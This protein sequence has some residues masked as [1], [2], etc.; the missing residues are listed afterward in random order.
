MVTRDMFTPTVDWEVY[1]GCVTQDIE[2]L[3]AICWTRYFE[4]HETILKAGNL[5]LAWDFAQSPQHY[6]RFVQMLRVTP[7][8]FQCLHDL[9]VDH[10]VF[11]S[12]SNRPQAPVQI[13]LSVF[14]F[15]TG[16]FGNGARV[17]DVARTAGI[18]E[19]TVHLFMQRVIVALLSLHDIAMAKPTAL[20][21]EAE[22]RGVM[23]SIKSEVLFSASAYLIW[24]PSPLS[25]PL[26]VSMPPSS[27]CTAIASTTNGFSPYRYRWGTRRESGT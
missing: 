3:L 27:F 26:T 18:L 12:W 23:L 7:T 9:I 1:Q 20:E 10:T 5:H 13:Q 25:L 17:T 15:H 14:L 24:P 22:K 4:V 2:I 19:G 16:R 8:S 11:M 21:I 6:H